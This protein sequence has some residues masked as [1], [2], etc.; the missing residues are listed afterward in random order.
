MSVTTGWQ[1]PYCL[2]PTQSI[3]GAPKVFDPVAAARLR[4][5]QTAVFQA[6]WPA[7]PRIVELA[8][9][10]QLVQRAVIA[11]AVAR[12]TDE[13][14]AAIWRDAS[15]GQDGET[16]FESPQKMRAALRAALTQEGKP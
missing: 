14:L 10:N 13:Q 2:G 6:M 15:D 9:G 7:T 3:N 16:W 8:I 11:E 12:L 1:C 5:V 4:E